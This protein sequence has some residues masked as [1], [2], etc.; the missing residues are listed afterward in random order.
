MLTHLTWYIIQ[1]AQQTN[2]AHR[3]SNL[4]E[5]QHCI[6]VLYLHILN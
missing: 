5:A 6:A 2:Q 4:A 1:G 3:F